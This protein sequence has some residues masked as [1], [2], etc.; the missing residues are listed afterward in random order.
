MA[1]TEKEVNNDITEEVNNN[2][3][4]TP[5]NAQTEQPNSEG[6][7]ANQEEQNEPSPDEQNNEQNNDEQKP[8]NNQ[9]S[10]KPK[11]EKVKDPSKKGII[12]R[13][14]QAIAWV[15]SYVVGA[16]VR[17]GVTIASGFHTKLVLDESERNDAKK[18][19][20][21]AEK[22]KDLNEKIEKEKEQ[23]MQDN[24]PKI[25]EAKTNEPKINEAPKGPESGDN[26][27]PNPFEEFDSGILKNSIYVQAIN[28]MVA[29]Y[30]NSTS[31]P[32]ER[33]R[34]MY[35]DGNLGFIYT[36]SERSLGEKF[37]DVKT[38]EYLKHDVSRE[39]LGL[40]RFGA[41]S[42][43]QN[44][45]RGD[46][47]AINCKDFQRF[48]KGIERNYYSKDYNNACR[49]AVF[50]IYLMSAAKQMYDMGKL[51]CEYYYHASHDRENDKTY[52]MK[53]SMDSKISLT[54]HD[55][56]GYHKVF[57]GVSIDKISLE[58]MEKSFENLDKEVTEAEQQRRAAEYEKARKVVRNYE[59]D[60]GKPDMD[61]TEQDQN[62]ASNEQAPEN[63]DQ[64]AQNNP[65]PNNEAQ[66]LDEDE[67]GRD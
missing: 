55:K 58:L 43:H 11:K 15:A 37:F 52:Q 48:E 31:L 6:N 53:I 8:S 26:P 45:L 17:L 42:Y 9:K 67:L 38:V 20:M 19:L 7:S 2:Q 32:E 34:L 36:T 51:P 66:N 14:G 21:N 61:K 56:N 46:E 27:K 59:Y 41:Y 62:N 39:N 50:S 16:L 28:K 5:E 57:S 4:E 29:D 24:E 23:F 33:P 40:T 60:H 10:K 35:E 63:S 22:I 49:N 47:R 12:K 1:S 54:Y 65:E 64:A 30:N 3:T 18:E 25:D 44:T 13:I